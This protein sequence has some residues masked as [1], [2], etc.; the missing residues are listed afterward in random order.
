MLLVTVATNIEL[1]PLL[2]HRTGG[3][4]MSVLV[5]GVGP[6]LAGI[7]LASWLGK[8]DKLPDAV[9]NFGIAGAYYPEE[10][11]E[12]VQL[13]DV[14]LAE[15]EVLGDFGICGKQEI[16]PLGDGKLW[17]SDFFV[18]DEMLLA[19]A[20][21][22]LDREQIPCKIGPFVTV[23]AASGT[24]KRA[25]M[26][27]GKHGGLCENMEGAAVALACRQFGIPCVE[28][29][30]VSNMV[31]DRETEEWKLKEA[32]KKAGQVAGFLAGELEHAV[33]GV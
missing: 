32:C 11:D 10:G 14:C 33:L 6:T 21:Q 31:G 22:I 29:R 26:I 7:R 28:L 12:G 27:T 9:L 18:M 25:D 16:T 24:K 13:L 8:S 30:V 3:T 5:T 17:G 1:Q 2:Q 23:N 4:G 20:T 19:A 15:S